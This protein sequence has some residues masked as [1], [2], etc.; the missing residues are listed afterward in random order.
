MERLEY[1]L[2]TS[3][4]LALEVPPYAALLGVY[5]PGDLPQERN[6]SVWSHRDTINSRTLASLAV[7]VTQAA[8][9]TLFRE[10]RLSHTG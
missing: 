6:N 3:C 8:V 7:M 2:V 10:L 5:G 1:S 9:E 4:P